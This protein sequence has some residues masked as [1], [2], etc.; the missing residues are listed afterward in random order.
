MDNYVILPSV[1]PNKKYDVMFI[2]PIKPIKKLLSFGGNPEKYS[3]YTQ[4]KD[5]ER[6][7]NYIKRHQVNEDWTNLKTAGTWARYI[8][9]NQKTLTKSI[10]DM[11]KRFHIKITLIK[12][13]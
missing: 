4:H 8:L 5:D 11:E 13:V 1:N 9:W 2:D 6:K 3:D 7:E 12:N 10:K